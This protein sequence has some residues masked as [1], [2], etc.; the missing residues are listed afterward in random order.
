MAGL[1]VYGMFLTLVNG[2]GLCSGD[3]I[4]LPPEGVRYTHALQLANLTTMTV[5]LSQIIEPKTTSSEDSCDR[6][7]AH[8]AI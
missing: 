6:A 4:H 1:Y 3:C 5:F 7:A 8:R 2:A